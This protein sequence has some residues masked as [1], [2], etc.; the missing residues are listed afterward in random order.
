MFAHVCVFR[1]CSLWKLSVSVIRHH[2]AAT[3]NLRLAGIIFFITL[4]EINFGSFLSHCQGSGGENICVP[5]LSL[6]L[7]CHPTPS[8]SGEALY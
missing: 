5:W 7:V 4:L 8:T 2:S 6:E 3:V 1:A